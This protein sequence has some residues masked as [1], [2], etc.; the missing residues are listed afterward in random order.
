MEARFKEALRA[1]GNVRAAARA[2]GFAEGGVWQRRR[3]WPAFA[4]MLHELLKEA[5]LVLE[6]RNA[7]MGSNFVPVETGTVTRNCPRGRV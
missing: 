3:A 4:V 5:G 6:L 2:V 7:S 1:C